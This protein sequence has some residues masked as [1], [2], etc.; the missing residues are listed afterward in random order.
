MNNTDVQEVLTRALEG[1]SWLVVDSGISYSWWACEPDRKIARE[2]LDKAANAL[3][4]VL[5]PGAR[6][7]IYNG[8]MPGATEY[9]Y[10]QR[11]L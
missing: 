6:A 1:V 3:N 7:S 4:D 8:Q 5:P 9:R 11:Y 2:E 10:L